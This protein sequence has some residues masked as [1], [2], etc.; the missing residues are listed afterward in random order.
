MRAGCPFALTKSGPKIQGD[1]PFDSETGEIGSQYD[2]AGNSIVNNAT[3]LREVAEL[4][5]WMYRS[6]IG[7]KLAQRARNRTGEMWRAEVHRY[8]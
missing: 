6:A 2:E 8:N 4:S 7:F 3:A 1:K 5:T